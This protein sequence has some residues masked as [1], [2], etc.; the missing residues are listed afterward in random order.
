MVVIMLRHTNIMESENMKVLKERKITNDFTN[1]L[2]IVRNI[3]EALKEVSGILNKLKIDPVFSKIEVDGEVYNVLLH[4]YDASENGLYL[5][6][7]EMNKIC[8]MFDEYNKYRNDYSIDIDDITDG[9]N[10][11]LDIGNLKI[12]GVRPYIKHIVSMEIEF[13]KE[14]VNIIEDANNNLKVLKEE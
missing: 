14:S 8:S 6:E 12:P 4:S 9:E 11:S 7:D 10:F 1:I 5:M 2:C 13:E 3:P